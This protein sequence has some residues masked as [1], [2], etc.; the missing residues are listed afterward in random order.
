M[1]SAVGSATLAAPADPVMSAELSLNALLR[2]ASGTRA[3]AASQPLA[4]TSRPLSAGEGSA[5]AAQRQ[6][7][8]PSSTPNLSGRCGGACSPRQPVGPDSTPA[9]VAP[10]VWH[11]QYRK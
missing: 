7:S 11:G 4:L 6:S 3:P 10:S 1:S 5:G 9:S 8:A 2:P